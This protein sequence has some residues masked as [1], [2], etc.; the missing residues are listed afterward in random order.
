[1]SRGL[2]F[3]DQFTRVS[4]LGG[5]PR[6]KRHPEELNQALHHV[7]VVL[8][9]EDGDAP[10]TITPATT[11]NPTP[12]PV[13]LA[14]KETNE[15]LLRT[16]QRKLNAPIVPDALFQELDLLLEPYNDKNR[17]S[18]ASSSTPKLPSSIASKSRQSNVHEQDQQETDGIHIQE[19]EDEDELIAPQTNTPKISLPASLIIALHS[20]WTDLIENTE[21]KYKVRFLSFLEKKFIYFFLIRLGEQKPVKILGVVILNIDVQ[22]S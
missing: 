21:Y 12:S 14:P 8:A 5:I 6:Y 10:K 2:Y 22:E 11:I 9:T 7:R 19:A 18:S 15:G 20:T 16:I 13:K 4:H 17:T 3:Y 1:M